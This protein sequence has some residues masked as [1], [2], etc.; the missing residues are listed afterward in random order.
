MKG[1]GP[2]DR[3][4]VH[5]RDRPVQDQV[6]TML[7]LLYADYVKGCFY[8]VTITLC[9][10]CQR[11]FLINSTKGLVPVSEGLYGTVDI[12]R[13]YFFLRIIKKSRPYSKLVYQKYT[14]TLKV[15]LCN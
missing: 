10:L 5:E 8:N 12:L 7:Q 3:P 15:T 9:R 14:C 4:A 13:K 1:I 11:M 6:F 2:G